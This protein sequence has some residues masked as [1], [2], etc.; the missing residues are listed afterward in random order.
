MET[1]E[2]MSLWVEKYRPKNIQDMI[3]EP[4]LKDKFEKL[5]DLGD[6][7]HLMF[8]GTPGLGKTTLAK[9]LCKQIGMEYYFVNASMDANI[10]LLRDK[11]SQFARTVSL[12]E[13][14]K[15]VVI[16]DECDMVTSNN[17]LPALRP[18]FEE[19]AKNCVFILT[20]NYFEKMPDYIRTRCQIHNFVIGD[21]KV[22]ANKIM[23]RL[24]EILKNEKVECN[25]AILADIITNNF[26]DIRKMINICQQYKDNLT[27]EK[28]KYKLTG[29]D[30][31]PL[32]KAMKEKDFNGIK[33]FVITDLTYTD[34]IYRSVYDK[35]KDF[36][37]P[38][39]IPPAILV[40]NEYQKFHGFALDKEIHII[41]FLLEFSNNI[42]FK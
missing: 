25:K 17:F 23:K 13:D 35:L 19:Y 9:V 30:I 6:L 41:S 2:E 26:P 32:I 31:E 5:I 36:V 42:K 15:K 21:K 8:Y 7:P 14:K 24:L 1:N 20:L 27:D 4:E 3:L 38:S 33:E 11:I 22:H 18:M 16:L 39:S 28:F 34:G 10:D 29:G 12:M 37:E 40:L